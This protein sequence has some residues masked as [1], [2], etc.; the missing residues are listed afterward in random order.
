MHGRYGRRRGPRVTVGRLAALALIGG[1]IG[2][3]GVYITHDPISLSVSGVENGVTLHRA[4]VEGLKIR[5]NASGLGA[6]DVDVRLNGRSVAVE[7]EGGAL[8][9]S[10][11]PFVLDG[12][13]DLVVNVHGRFVFSDE[14]TTRTFTAVLTG[15]TVSVPAQLV[16]RTDGNPLV[17][18]GLV[19]DATGL[20]VGGQPTGFDG[21][22][23]SVSVDQRA[24]SVVVRA[25]HANG[26]VTEK[27]VAIVDAATPAAYPTTRAV[28]ITAKGWADPEV[29][30][31]VM[32]LV[33]DGSITA[34]ELDIKDEGGQVGYASAVP[35][36]T[37]AGAARPLYDPTAAIAE[38]HGAG[39]RVIGRIVCFLD[40]VLA[41]WA[42]STGRGDM[43]V[44]SAG[45]SSPLSNGYGSAAFT[46]F[47]DPTVQQ[48]LID[49]SVEAAKHG[50]DDVLYDYVRR[51]E[52]RESTMTV[53]GL[54]RPADVEIAR[55]VRDTRQA[56][57]PYGTKLG[58]SV[59]GISATRPEQIAQDIRLLAPNVDYIAPMVY[60]SVWGN[61]EYGVGDPSRQPGDIVERSLTDFVAVAAGSG[62][63]VVPWLQAY[64]ANG[65]DYGPAEVQL[66][67]DAARRVGASGFLL[68]NAGSRYSP[69]DVADRP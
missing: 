38:L 64:S 21:G 41:G 8:V 51:P 58:V 63:A 43:V 32:A 27:S 5:I 48:Y 45:G 11:A 7:P 56:L 12:V 47:A 29:H 10:P 19:D 50:F 9:A 16:R 26:N 59:F 36:T 34:V 3:T 23:F 60:P 65:V 25:T 35:L 28:H 66:Q 2:A 61:G 30:Q 22:A 68:W 40:P 33:A 39:V 24:A 6:G 52:G 1:A 55:F 49:L 54:S 17:L 18:R 14:A 44:Q 15:A 4:Q 31:R 62:A 67:I 53:P 42:W 69:G 13:N 37:S 57:A 20:E 46:N